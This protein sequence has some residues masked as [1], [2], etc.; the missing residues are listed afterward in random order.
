MTEAAPP[1][2][3]LA[4]AHWPAR[5]RALGAIMHLLGDLRTD[6]VVRRAFRIQPGVALARYGLDG[7]LAEGELPVKPALAELPLTPA[8]LFGTRAAS[9]AV[10]HIP[11]ELRFIAYGLKP[12]ALLQGAE[13]ELLP[14]LA[15]AE[16][17]GWCAL[18]SPREWSPIHDQ[19]KGGYANLASSPRPALPGSGA[20]RS[21][22]VSPDCDRAIQIWLAQALQWDAYIGRLLGYPS[23]CAATF[24]ERWPAAI[25]EH[26]GD[27]LPLSLDASGPGPH[28]WHVNIVARYFGPALIQHFPCRFDCPESIAL[29]RRVGAA[30]AHFEPE[31]LASGHRLLAAPALYSDRG[32]IAI[33]VGGQVT[34]EGQ[35]LRIDFDPQAMLVTEPMGA[36][37][38]ALAGVT[39]LTV[40]ATGTVI[41][42]GRAIDARVALFVDSGSTPQERDRDAISAFA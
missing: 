23:C 25:A 21:L 10:G 29:A 17:R 32:G 31:Y 26:Q 15:W 13:D 34:G 11:D 4:T 5:R 40:H 36:L 24:A 22:I 14:Y 8:H 37:V 20:H 28:D 1:N 9:P 35:Q 42:A 39:E 16:A 3:A 30:L 33:L 7:S 12:A 27:L 19:G 2:A 6:P 38:R 18:L 41:A